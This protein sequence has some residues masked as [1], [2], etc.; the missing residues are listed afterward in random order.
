MKTHN[1]FKFITQ[2]APGWALVAGTL[3]AISGC[4]SNDTNT[5]KTPVKP[6]VETP[7]RSQMSGE[8]LFK[9]PFPGAKN[10]RTCATCHV[11]ED[12]FTLTPAHVAKVFKENPNDPLFSAIDA[13][14]PKAIPLTFEHLKKG[15]IRVWLTI[16]ANMDLI[17][18][19][20]NITTPADRKIFVWRGV[21]S[22]ADAALTAPYQLD[23]RAKNLVEQ[24]QG[25]VEGH[26]E[27]TTT[28]ATELE[29]I[30][31]FERLTFSSSR[32]KKVADQLAKGVAPKD[33][34]DVD[35]ELVLTPEETRGR[36]LYKKVCASCHGGPNKATIVDR[37][38]HD[39]SFYA[40]KPDGNVLYSV[41]ATIP[42]T[43]VLA[44][45]PDNEFIN[46][47]SAMENFLAQIGATEHESFTRDVSFPAYRFRFYKDESKQVVVA[48]LPPKTAPLD[49]D[50]GGFFEIGDGSGQ[51]VVDTGE[52]GEGGGDFAPQESD[53]DGNPIMGPNGALQL[54]TTD[55]GRAII[56]GNP[57][58][59][60]AFD[61]PTLRG[62][63][64][65]APYWHNHISE[66]L[67]DVVELYSDHL[68]ARYPSF[69]QPGEKEADCDGDTGP[70]EAFTKQQKAD[71]VAYLKR[72]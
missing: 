60:E 43:P 51:C 21:P 7:Q 68:L 18:A 40:L 23:G 42:A 36:E 55:P 17:D 14:D 6:P 19:E 26:S 66:K 53:S 69:I 70:E 41:P 44:D 48:E 9:T 20:G 3:V 13:D 37:A 57:Y 45:Q 54:F 29:R 56:T 49:G 65:S 10:Q 22:I 46:I 33:I 5:V 15:L 38:I 47:G 50:G 67:E 32:A 25:A 1:W 31:D 12:N 2:S 4:N 34:P 59:F 52:G 28:Q 62:I 71:L 24:A 16:P 11:P 39:A 58:D 8:V 63:S 27:G 64:K 35:E 61:I 72:L 30:A